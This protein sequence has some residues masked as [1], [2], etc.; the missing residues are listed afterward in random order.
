MYINI[1]INS[2]SFGWQISDYKSR[3]EC[4]ATDIVETERGKTSSETGG[5]TNAK[6]F[7]RNG[8]YKSKSIGNRSLFRYKTISRMV[9]CIRKFFLLNS[10]WSRFSG[11]KVCENFFAIFSSICLLKI[12]TID[13]IYGDVVR[14][15]WHRG[16]LTSNIRNSDSVNGTQFKINRE[17]KTRKLIMS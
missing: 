12:R 11:E 9:V 17:K 7:A 14:Q 15:N 8:C 10:P 2:Y 16:I 3:R 1:Y 4:V 6:L 5:K 13:E